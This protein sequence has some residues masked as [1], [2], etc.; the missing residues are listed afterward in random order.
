MDVVVRDGPG[1]VAVEA[2]DVVCRLLAAKPDAVLGL[3]TGRTPLALYE[4]LVRRCRE[5]GVSFRRATVFALDELLGLRGGD[6]RSFRATLQGAIVARVDLDSTRFHSP[7][8]DGGE[9]EGLIARAGGL[10]L[11]LL[12]IGRNGHIA[13]NEPG[14][15]RESRTR[16]VTLATATVEEMTAAFAPDPPPREAVTMG[17]ATILESRRAVL[18]AV[19]S[20]KAPAVARAASGPI[21]ASCPASWLRAH[22]EASLVIDAA[23]A[24]RRA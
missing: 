13:F 23:A 19:G 9:Y 20:G 14:S 21:D 10:D 24:G 22:A 12:G 1:Q 18:L 16:R 17:I 4:E 15:A 7:E 2:A 8:G 11:V 3:P 5:G 6:P